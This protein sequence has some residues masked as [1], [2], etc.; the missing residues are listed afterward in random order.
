MKFLLILFLWNSGYAE[1]NS[2]KKIPA[3]T[4]YTSEQ[5]KVIYE[6]SEARGN[7][8]EQ[9]QIFDINDQLDY[10]KY[11]FMGQ[12]TCICK[13]G[14][15]YVQH[16]CDNIL[17]RRQRSFVIT[18]KG[19]T[20]CIYNSDKQI[21][22][23]LEGHQQEQMAQSSTVKESTAPASEGTTGEATAGTHP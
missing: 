15:S 19:I 13:K 20:H 12:Q 9:Q 14:L 18:S 23:L 11:D 21:N 10:K 6:R 3:T 5:L 2:V 1:M 17:G 4:N 16:L 8:K 22:A 7:N